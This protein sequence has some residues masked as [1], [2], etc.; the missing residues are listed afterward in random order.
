[1]SAPPPAAGAGGSGPG[2]GSRLAR[3]A[4]QTARQPQVVPPGGQ[5][6]AQHAQATAAHV[7]ALARGLASDPDSVRVEAED[8]SVGWGCT[9]GGEV[10][11]QLSVGG[12]EFWLADESPESAPLAIDDTLR[13]L[14]HDGAGEHEMERHA[15]QSSASIRATTISR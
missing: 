6:L 2:G 13:S 4:G 3:P 14:I 5:I 10:V 7:A 12:A 1:M 8:G 11:A 9:N 15:R